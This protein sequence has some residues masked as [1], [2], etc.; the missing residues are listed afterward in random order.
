MTFLHVAHTSVCALLQRGLVV[1]S[2]G[3]GTQSECCFSVIHFRSLSLG[4]VGCYTFLSGCQPSWP[5]TNSTERE[6][7]FRGS[8][9]ERSFGLLMRC[10]RFSPRRQYC[11]P[12]VAHLESDGLSETRRSHANSQI[13][14][15]H[16][17]SP[18]EERRP[19]RR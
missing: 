11:L 19:F 8:M 18:A 16:G 15:K 10:Y 14:C 13:S 1:M 3:N 2:S 6:T 17:L 9:D 4:Q 7:A 12:V 5:P